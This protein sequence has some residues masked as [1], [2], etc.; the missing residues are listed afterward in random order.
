MKNTKIS[1]QHDLRHTASFG[2]DMRQALTSKNSQTR[3]KYQSKNLEDLFLFSDSNAE[4][5]T[6]KD[7]HENNQAIRAREKVENFTD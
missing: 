1:K 4:D 3:H 5:K 7:D 2:V 6:Q